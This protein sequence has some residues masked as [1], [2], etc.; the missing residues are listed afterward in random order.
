[1]D[2]CLCIHGN[3]A[4][5]IKNSR[6][7]QRSRNCIFVETIIDKERFMSRIAKL[8]VYVATIQNLFVKDRIVN[9]L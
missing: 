2:C 6:N 1:M 3:I 8:Y 5:F 7:K 4:L 9:G